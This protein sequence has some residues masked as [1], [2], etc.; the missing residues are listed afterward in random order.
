MNFL[1]IHKTKARKRREKRIA[2]IG[3]FQIAISP[4]PLRISVGTEAIAPNKP[5]IVEAG[6]RV[7]LP[8]E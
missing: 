5:Q 4:I 2:N 8:S 3:V 1:I 7:E 6:V